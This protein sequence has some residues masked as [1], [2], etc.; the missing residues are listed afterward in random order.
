MAKNAVEAIGLLPPVVAEELM[1]IELASGNPWLLETVVRHIRYLK[2]I[3]EPTKD[4]V[5]GYF[6]AAP[7]RQ[8]L[9]QHAATLRVL[10][11]SEHMSSVVRHC[12]WLKLEYVW[13]ATNLTFCVIL[14][15]HIFVVFSYFLFLFAAWR[16]KIA[17]F[18]QARVPSRPLVQRE[19]SGAGIFSERS[20]LAIVG[21]P[22]SFVFYL[23]A[24][25]ISLSS[26][27]Q[28]VV[29]PFAVTLE[30]DALQNSDLAG[31]FLARYMNLLKYVPAKYMELL[32]YFPPVTKPLPYYTLREHLDQNTY[33]I[34]LFLFAL[35]GAPWYSIGVSIFRVWGARR[36]EAVLT[37][38]ARAFAAVI[39]VLTFGTLI[40]IAIWI[41]DMHWSLRYTIF[42]L[43]G[44]LFTAVLVIATSNFCKFLV[45]EF[46]GIRQA[47][48]W[49]KRFDGR[50][51][52]IAMAFKDIATARG[53]SRF[54]DGVAT[55]SP[56]LRAVLQR[57]DDH[58]PDG[59]RPNLGDLAST[60]LAQLE[61]AWLGL[62]R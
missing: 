2:S 18:Q 39:A 35:S 25:L 62:D 27:N 8:L 38:L 55:A 36:I 26:L 57:P 42:F 19:T 16:P 6:S 44:F 13:V 61:E 40:A 30:I 54:I 17:V 7:R 59:A 52:T 24:I 3:S 29:T 14:Y 15:P 49:A 23:A 10:A 20:P 47:K 41:A 12:K 37:I 11:L 56:Q 28:G 43:I 60:R 22:G 53:R 31:E 1:S 46:R 51:T 4:L 48:D 32:E 21:I 33:R 45:R 34:L 9:G 50:R 5:K 58:W